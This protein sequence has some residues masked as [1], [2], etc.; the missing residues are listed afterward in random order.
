MR[1]DHSRLRR[2]GI[3]VATGAL[4]VVGIVGGANAAGAGEKTIYAVENGLRPCFSE[5]AKQTCEPD[6]SPTVRIR[7]GDKVTWN[8]G[9]GVHNAA[10]DGPET[11]NQAWKDRKSPLVVPAVPQS[12]E[13][14]E[15]GTYK[16][17]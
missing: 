14:G 12:Y 1:T 11:A 13:F 8:F 7:T 4:V 15:A 2:P 10:S 9:N 6:E 3:A 5:T 16:F 17:I